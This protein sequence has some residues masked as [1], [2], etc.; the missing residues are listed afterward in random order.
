M[1]RLR[2]FTKRILVVILVIALS[3]VPSFEVHAAEKE[4]DFSV[5]FIDVGQGDCALI[6]CEGHYMMIDGGPADASATIYTILKERVIKDIDLIV[7]TH[8]DADH[9][10]GLSAALNFANV[11]TVLSPVKSHDTKTFRNFEKYVE[12]QNRSFTMPVYGDIYELGSAVVEILGPIYDNAESNNLS[13]V[14]KVTYGDNSFLFMGDAEGEEEE[15]ILRRN[16]TLDCDVIKIGHHGSCSSTSDALLNA[17][18]PKYAVISVGNDNTYGHPTKEILDKLKKTNVDIYR[19]DLQGDIT[20]V[21]D[22]KKI[23]VSTEKNA[24]SQTVNNTKDSKTQNIVPSASDV[25][26]PANTKYVLNTRSMKFHYPECESVAKMSAKNKKYSSDSAENIVAMGYSPCM[27][28]NP[29]SGEIPQTYETVEQIVETTEVIQTEQ[30]APVAGG[31]YVLNTRS[32][33]FHY[34]YCESVGKM[35]AHNRQDV[36][37]T[38]DEIIGWGYVP[39][40]NCNP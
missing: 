24:S 23:T 30:V 38:R 27:I 35:A 15:D 3:I 33:K 21:S 39:C 20:F 18:K 7:A 40:M 31:S 28:C 13:I 36:T 16:K 22:G 17:V 25:Q 12:K 37:A 6:Q 32:Y 9:I 8:P 11:E 2:D 34:P 1:R 10:G 14:V 19:T 4:P 29:Y 26:K 5:E